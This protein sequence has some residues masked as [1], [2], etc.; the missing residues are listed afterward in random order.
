MVRFAVEHANTKGL[1]VLLHV[2]TQLDVD[3][4]IHG[5]LCD[6][7]VASST[8]HRSCPLHAS[9]NCRVDIDGH[10]QQHL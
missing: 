9:D 8:L 6:A 2:K 1:P 5:F 7:T 4:Y 10:A 3:A